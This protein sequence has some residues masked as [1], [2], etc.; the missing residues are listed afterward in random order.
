MERL[1]RS[2]QPLMET[3][4]KGR[5]AAVMRSKIGG[6]V[7]TRGITGRHG[8]SSSRAFGCGDANAYIFPTRIEVLRAAGSQRADGGSWQRTDC[9]RRAM[10]HAT[11]LV[12]RGLWDVWMLNL[13][14]DFAGDLPYDR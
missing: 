9:R 11:T 13:A 1:V 6:S 8:Q 3:F 14:R 12:P 5:G 2:G 10:L 7:T 4:R